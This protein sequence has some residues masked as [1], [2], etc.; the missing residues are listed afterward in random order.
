MDKLDIF[1]IPF[2]Y[3]FQLTLSLIN[4]AY[5]VVSSTPE[6]SKLGQYTSIF[7]LF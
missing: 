1:L 7:R 5:S 4:L 2:L 3:F 6:F